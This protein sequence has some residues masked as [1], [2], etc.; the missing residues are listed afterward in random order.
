MS[1][2]IISTD[3]VIHNS[4]KSISL[5]YFKSFLFTLIFKD[6]SKL[7]PI[8]LLALFS[9]MLKLQISLIFK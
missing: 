8:T 2:S 4:A 5:R 6:A 7:D 1:A 9:S 3:E